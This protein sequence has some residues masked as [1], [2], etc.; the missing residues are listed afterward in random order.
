MDVRKRFDGIEH[1][2]TWIFVLVLPPELNVTLVLLHDVVTL[3]LALA[4][5]IAEH[6]LD[7]D[8]PEL[9]G[10]V[11]SQ[12]LLLPVSIATVMLSTLCFF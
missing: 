3:Q 5:V 8:Q 1:R 12:F 6:L 11:A 10:F 2:P 9:A 4:D 7:L